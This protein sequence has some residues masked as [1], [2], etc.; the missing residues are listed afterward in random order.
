MFFRMFDLKY[1]LREQ[2]FPGFAYGRP[3]RGTFGYQIEGTHG[4]AR[5]RSGAGH[6]AGVGGKALV[7]GDVDKRGE[8]LREEAYH[9]VRLCPGG[10]ELG[11]PAR[12]ALEAAPAAADEGACVDVALVGADAAKHFLQELLWEEY[13]YEIGAPHLIA[14]VAGRR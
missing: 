11:G 8:P 2:E 7:D 6:R 5:S 12:G 10:R 9:L 4:A 1:S 14:A 13:V 3:K